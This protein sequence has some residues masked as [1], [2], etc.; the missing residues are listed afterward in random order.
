MPII[1]I[2]FDNEK[3]S[4]EEI[5]FLSETIQKIVS[6]TTNIEDV[7]VYANSSKIKINVAPVEIFIEM[8]TSKIKDADNLIKDIKSKLSNWKAENNFKYPINLTLIPMNW[9]IETNI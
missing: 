8:S 9:K 1:R 4:E 5:R 2:D 3:V 6:T 7:F